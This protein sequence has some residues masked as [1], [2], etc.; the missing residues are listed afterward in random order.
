MSGPLVSGIFE[1]SPDDHRGL[2]AHY[3]RASLVE[4]KG[5]L[6][7]V[8]MLAHKS[9][10]VVDW[11]LFCVDESSSDGVPRFNAGIRGAV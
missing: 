11:N 7:E 10:L 6:V 8:S 5:I 2:Y 4:M 3:G 9:V 1:G